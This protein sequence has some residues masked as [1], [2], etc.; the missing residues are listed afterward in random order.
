MY[1]FLLHVEYCYQARQKRLSKV[2]I[3]VGNQQWTEDI[4]NDWVILFESFLVISVGL[5][6]GPP[7]PGGQFGGV[8]GVESHSG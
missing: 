2:Q 8:F 3:G 7:V 5:Q 1:L 6:I 4:L